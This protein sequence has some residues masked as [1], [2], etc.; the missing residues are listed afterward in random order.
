MRSIQA[1][2]FRLVSVVPELTP[3]YESHIRA[4]G[5]LVGEPLAHHFGANLRRAARPRSLGHGER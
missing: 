1:W 2:V 4:N 5:S 3:L